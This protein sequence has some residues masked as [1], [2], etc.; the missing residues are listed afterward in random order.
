MKKRITCKSHCIYWNDIDKDCEL[1][2]DN[3]PCPRKC[4]VYKKEHQTT[5]NKF[6]DDITDQECDALAAAYGCGK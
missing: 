5:G 2:G 1:M 4:P 3:H 6:L